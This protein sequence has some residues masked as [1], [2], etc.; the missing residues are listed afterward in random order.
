MNKSYLQSM[1]IFAIANNLMHLSFDE[2]FNK[3]KQTLI[4][5]NINN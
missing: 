1:L 2:V 3:F 5:R 4:Y